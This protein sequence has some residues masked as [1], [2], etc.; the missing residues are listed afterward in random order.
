MISSDKSPRNFPVTTD[1]LWI[2]IGLAGAGSS[3]DALEAFNNLARAYWPPLFEWL[4]AKTQLPHQDAEDLVNSFFAS[5]SEKRTLATAQKARGHFH[6]FLC[7]CIQNFYLDWLDRQRALKRGGGV[8][9]VSSDETDENGRP[10]VISIGEN[11]DEPDKT[12]ERKLAQAFLTRVLK[13]LEKEYET[14]N[15]TTLFRHLMGH[16]YGEPEAAK[17]QE[18]ARV[19]GISEGAVKVAGHRLRTRFRELL[20]EEAVPEIEEGQQ[21]SDYIN[22]LF[23]VLS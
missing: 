16:L 5:V 23:Q 12:L 9:H 21:L 10:I 2:Q 17:H 14:Q 19:L 8:I 22:H 7:K 1:S 15:K 3:P 13:R 18:A 4:K 20:Y 11:G 6:S